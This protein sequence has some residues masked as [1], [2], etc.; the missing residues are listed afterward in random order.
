M[1]DVA[2]IDSIVAAE[3]PTAT[4]LPFSTT[5]ESPTSTTPRTETVEEV[6]KTRTIIV[7]D[8]RQ[9]ESVLPFDASPLSL[10]RPPIPSFFPRFFGRNSGRD[11]NHFFLPNGYVHTLRKRMDRPWS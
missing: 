2:L 10:T 1:R 6:I 9:R 4:V 7:T 5:T 11:A 8:T 3:D